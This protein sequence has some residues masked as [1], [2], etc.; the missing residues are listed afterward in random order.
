MRSLI[1]TSRIEQKERYLWNLAQLEKYAPIWSDAITD[2]SESWL[3]QLRELGFSLVRNLPSQ[4]LEA[5]ISSI[6]PI[7]HKFRYGPFSKSQAI[8]NAQDLS[9]SAEGYALLPHTDI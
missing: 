1:K 7:H 3:S 8:P 6:G 5:F 4:E 2:L 9:Q